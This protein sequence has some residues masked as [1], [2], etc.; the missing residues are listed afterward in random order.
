[1][2][3]KKTL[4]RWILFTTIITFIVIAV[5][6]VSFFST[7]KMGVTVSCEGVNHY[8]TSEGY[9]NTDNWR[10][11]DV[12][13][14]DADSGEL[15]RCVYI[16]DS[17][18]YVSTSPASSN[19]T[20]KCSVK[21]SLKI[22]FDETLKKKGKEIQSKIKSCINNSTCICTIN[23]HVDQMNDP[24]A[25]INSTSMKSSIIETCEALHCPI[26]IVVSKMVYTTYY[27]LELA[28]SMAH[29]G[30]ADVLKVGNL[31]VK[32]NYDCNESL[33]KQA[34]NGSGTYLRYSAFAYDKVSKKFTRTSINS[35]RP[36]SEYKIASI[37]PEIL[38]ARKYGAML[39][40]VDGRKY[41]NILGSK[42][43]GDDD[44]DDCPIV[45]QIVDTSLPVLSYISGS[46]ANQMRETHNSFDSDFYTR[47]DQD[48][49]S[50]RIR[51]KRK[52][53]EIAI[54]GIEKDDSSRENLWADTLDQVVRFLRSIRSNALRKTEI[55]INDFR[56]RI[57]GHEHYSFSDGAKPPPASYLSSSEN[58]LLRQ[59]IDITSYKGRRL[60]YTQYFFKYNSDKDIPIGTVVVADEND[61]PDG[62]IE[63]NGAELDA[64]KYPELFHIIHKNFSS[65]KTTFKLPRFFGSYIFYEYDGYLSPEELC[66][67][68]NLR[69]DFVVDQ[70]KFASKDNE[71]FKYYIKA[72]N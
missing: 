65:G 9:L 70:F 4:N 15:T 64:E 25:A 19:D 47:I 57:K 5:V 68:S 27:S 23:S 26:I 41:S 13:V 8:S 53:D 55:A 44:D 52:N 60:N 45:I 30:R 56:P 7:E 29:E 6:L 1:M 14:F 11:G 62:W 50:M 67:L 31:E 12:F 21:S 72:K 39:A 48:G 28:T 10:M 2:D 32:V 33:K 38:K 35:K 24:L 46:I 20:S 37:Q 42:V 16:P 71:Y 61:F 63:C 66:I 58:D 34:Q 59:S 36:L 40:C 18:F 17:E 54:I 49:G 43:R 22:E 69:H 3:R 51:K